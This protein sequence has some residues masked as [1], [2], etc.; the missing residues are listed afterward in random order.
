[1]IFERLMRRAS[2]DLAIDLGTANTL[3]YRT[4]AGI[5]CNEPSVVA[6]ER[7]PSR[8]R[9]VL[10][11]GEDA[12]RMLGR[13]PGHI[14]AIRPLREGV[15]ADFEIAEAMLRYFI[16]EARGSSALIRPRVILCV[17]FGCTEVEKRAVREA[18][19][20]A[21]AREVQLVLEPV[22]AAM[23]AGLPMSEPTGSMIV[24]IGGGTTEVAVLS[25]AGVVFSRSVRVGGDQM[26]EA[27]L[28][29]V[30]RK[31]NLLIGEQTAERVKRTLG[32][33]SPLPERSRR[34][35]TIQ[36]RDLIGGVPKTI[37]VGD[38]EIREALS[39]TVERIIEAVRSALERCPPELSADIVDEGIVLAGGGALLGNLSE[40][41]HEETGLSVR[42][43]GVPLTAVALGAGRI[44]DGLARTD[45]VAF[46]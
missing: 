5:V 32:A 19:L 11:V 23:G 9:R 42:L 45:D 21:G 3:I 18:A 12:K 30:K 8:D 36:G 22:A 33:A 31:H 28:Q 40:R 26:D 37:Q 7:T 20:S 17:P 38:E 13:T 35:M 4:G 34:S 10:A 39:E 24:D 15:V 46:E 29:H 41:I 1:M 27:I 25:L 43:C 14:E 44:L 16:R 2:V 6:V